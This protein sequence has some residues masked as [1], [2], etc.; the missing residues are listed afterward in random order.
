M[1][2]K[3]KMTI[4]AIGLLLAAEAIAGKKQL[5]QDAIIHG[6]GSGLIKDSQEKY[7]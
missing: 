3:T 7:I 2:M 6:K 5:F 1:T 4:L